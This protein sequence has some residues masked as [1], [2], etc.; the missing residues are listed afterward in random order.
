MSSINA[1]E[2]LT[3]KKNETFLPTDWLCVRHNR[4]TLWPVCEAEDWLSKHLTPIRH[5]ID[6]VP[7]YNYTGLEENIN[8]MFGTLDESSSFFMPDSGET[9]KEDDISEVSVCM[10]S[11]PFERLIRLKTNCLLRSMGQLLQHPQSLARCRKIRV[12]MQF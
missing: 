3:Y 2:Q 6:K 5:H 9:S 8:G 1:K 4:D 10:G 11:I 12:N 7:P